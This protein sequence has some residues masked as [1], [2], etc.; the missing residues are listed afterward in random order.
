M[1]AIRIVEAAQ[2]KKDRQGFE[3][4]IRSACT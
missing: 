2:L 3:P 1:D 4:V